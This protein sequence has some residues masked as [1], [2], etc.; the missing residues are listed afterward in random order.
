M[1]GELTGAALMP[2]MGAALADRYGQ[3]MM[4]KP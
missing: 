1:T 3:A 4:D 2:S